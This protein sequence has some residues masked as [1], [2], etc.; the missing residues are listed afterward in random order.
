[1]RF[2]R[3][4]APVLSLGPLLNVY[5]RVNESSHQKAVSEFVEYLSKGTG[6]IV[7][8]K[9]GLEVS[10]IKSRIYNGADL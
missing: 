7:G 5:P 4:K 1:M 3:G 10:R 6:D 9:R 2:K 8:S